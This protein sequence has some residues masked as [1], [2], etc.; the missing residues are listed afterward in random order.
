[1]AKSIGGITYKTINGKRYAYYQWMEDG[2]RRSR[3]VKD[4]ELASL[5]AEIELK[6]A[7]KASSVL[8]SGD[9]SVAPVVAFRDITAKYSAG[10][11][12]NGAQ[13]FKTEVKAGAFLVNFY[14][15][16][17]QWKRLE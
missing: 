9:A 16:V 5:I 4:E 11:P 3:R 12:S 14:A 1:M 2:K 10:S 7:Q 13:V 17:L 6:K 15:N 8:K